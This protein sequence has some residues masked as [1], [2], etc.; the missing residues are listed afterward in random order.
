MTNRKAAYVDFSQEKYKSL[1]DD[2][3]QILKKINTSGSR[4]QIKDC[5]KHGLHVPVFVKMYDGG[6]S[7]TN[8]YGCPK[9]LEDRR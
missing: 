7:E 9:C 8:F 3:V 1:S 2:E 6:C 5:E 4:G